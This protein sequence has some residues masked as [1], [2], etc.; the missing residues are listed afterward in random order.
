MLSNALSNLDMA[1]MPPYVEAESLRSSWGIYSKV[2]W[3]TNQEALP[4]NHVLIWMNKTQGNL[5]CSLV[6]RQRNQGGCIRLIDPEMNPPNSLQDQIIYVC[7]VRRRYLPSLIKDP[8]DLEKFA[9]TFSLQVQEVDD[10][11]ASESM[12]LPTL[13]SRFNNKKEKIF[14][15][16]NGVG[17]RFSLGSPHKSLGS[18]SPGWGIFT[19]VRSEETHQEIPALH[20]LVKTE[21]NRFTNQDELVCKIFNRELSEDQGKLIPFIDIRMDPQNS[22][23]DPLIYV[24]MHRCKDLPY[25]KKGSQTLEPIAVTFRHPVTPPPGR[26]KLI[27]MI[28]FTVIGFFLLDDMLSGR[29]SRNPGIT[30]GMPLISPLQGE[31]DSTL[32]LNPSAPFQEVIED[33]RPSVVPCT[34]SS[35]PD[36]WVILNGSCTTDQIKSAYETQRKVFSE[37][38]K[39]LKENGK[40]DIE[41]FSTKEQSGI[42]ELRAAQKESISRWKVRT[43]SVDRLI[44]E[45]NAALYAE[46]DCELDEEYRGQ[47]GYIPRCRKIERSILGVEPWDNCTTIGSQ[48]RKL[49]LQYHPDKNSSAEAKEKFLAI[50][51]AHEILCPL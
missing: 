16:L 47:P 20:I 13:R 3:E 46:I 21:R 38:R 23:S 19:E 48:F 9:L 34:V 30:T 17:I 51:K 41:A 42:D 2:R 35:S 22:L 32:F 15:A 24:C 39:E 14:Q 5:V 49:S 50:N 18:V 28:F 45:E 43:E 7:N 11:G 12:A 40:R 1:L 26:A 29:L 4:F 10:E 31:G 37:K 6:D 33:V 8:Q 36:G 25:L 27:A 44:F